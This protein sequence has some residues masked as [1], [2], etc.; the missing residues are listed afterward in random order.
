MTGLC[1][2]QTE[3]NL[4]YLSMDKSGPKH[5]NMKLSR[6]KFEQIVDALIK[7]TV[8]PCQKAIQDA[9]VK[10]SEIGEIILVGGMTR[11]P[12]VCTVNAA[13]HDTSTWSLR[14]SLS[15]VLYFPC[16]DLWSFIF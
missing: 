4:P 7:K 11:V 16:G 5:L 14:T 3:I 15:I 1:C 8:S 6:S 2:V 12:K 9:N 10:P 13:Y